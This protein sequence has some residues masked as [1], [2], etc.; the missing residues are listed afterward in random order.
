[1]VG[2]RGDLVLNLFCTVFQAEDRGR[3]AKS[4]TED[5][6]RAYAGIAGNQ[7]ADEPARW[8]A[9]IKKTAVVYDRFPLS[10]MKKVIRV[11]S[12]EEWQKRYAEGSMNEIIKCFFL[13]MEQVYR[14]F[15]QIDMTSQIA[16]TLT[17]H[18]RTERSRGLRYNASGACGAENGNRH[19]GREAALPGD[20]RRYKKD[21]FLILRH[22]C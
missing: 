20:Y 22:G 8:A 2:R 7:P 21:F 16:Q 9:L 5:E 17:G 1:M 6:E 14:V 19:P 15:R 10:H 11:A 13:Q 3:G 12:L 4:D 18:G